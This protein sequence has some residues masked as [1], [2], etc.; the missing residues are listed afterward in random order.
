MQQIPFDFEGID[1]HYPPALKD[2]VTNILRKEGGINP[3]KLDDEVNWFFDHLGLPSTYFASQPAE[4]V[5]HHI[6]SIYADKLLCLANKSGGLKINICQEGPNGA[7]YACTSI[8]GSKH[9]PAVEIERRLSER[10]LSP[11]EDGSCFRVQVYRSTGSLSPTEKS[12]LRLYLVS[13]AFFGTK[14][15]QE[16][17]RS[18]N[19][20]D[21]NEIAD[22]YFSQTCQ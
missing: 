22:D 14:R 8:P 13:K 7:L 3:N 18:G 20:T 1:T 19:V 12:Q 21:L 16:E 11:H 5:S 9:S 6:T 10:Y 15:S 2:E 4:A 17:L